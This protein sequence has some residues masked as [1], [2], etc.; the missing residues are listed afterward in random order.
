M[1][2]ELSPEVLLQAYDAHIAEARSDLAQRKAVRTTLQL[3]HDVVVKEKQQYLAHLR[4]KVKIRITTGGDYTRYSRAMEECYD[5]SGEEKPVLNVLR[6]QAMLL[7]I[8][9]KCEVSKKVV[10]MGAR[11][12][13][14][15]AQ[16]LLK[17]CKDVEDEKASMQVVYGKR[18]KDK[19]SS[20]EETKQDFLQNKILPQR[21][22]INRLESLSTDMMDL[23]E[24][25]MR[26][27]QRQSKSIQQTLKEKSEN[28]RKLR[29]NSFEKAKQRRDSLGSQKTADLAADMADMLD[30]RSVASHKSG[31]SF[32][33]GRSGRSAKSGRSAFTAGGAKAW[34]GSFFGKSSSTTLESEMTPIPLQIDL[35]SAPPS[36]AYQFMSGLLDKGEMD[37]RK[38][39]D[40]DSLDNDSVTDS[41]DTDPTSSEVIPNEVTISLE[42]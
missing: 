32:R 15:F 16:S 9:H 10:D 38:S 37:D 14:K 25:M 41:A 11:Q 21:M 40:L 33:S 2:S 35:K 17:D 31:W 39:V 1:A 13:K 27:R 30:D 28:F 19:Q 24:K 3:K 36:S 5:A 23:Q 4:R 22:V 18:R 34:V 7:S 29:Q 12:N 20:F 6:R 8:T 26:R 42:D